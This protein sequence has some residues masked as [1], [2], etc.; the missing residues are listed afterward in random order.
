[1]EAF[2]VIPSIERLLQRDAL[3]DAIARHGHDSISAAA[4]QAADELRAA[5]ASA[6]IS[7]AGVS[8]AES[9]LTWLEGRT[10]ALA[11]ARTRASLRRVINAT[12][13]I[14]HTNLGR[15][16][17]AASA[18]E[19]ARLSLGYSNLEYDLQKG[20]RGHRH[21]HAERLLTELTGAEAAVVVNNTAAA[22][23]PKSIFSIRSARVCPILISISVTSAATRSS[24]T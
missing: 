22:A 7:S 9:A 15:A 4:R 1:M 10:L 8:D 16:P 2:R 13:V 19:N 18:F 21:V 23:L 11:A 24:N 12:G 5:L 14:I 3:R 20:A 17:L 6:T